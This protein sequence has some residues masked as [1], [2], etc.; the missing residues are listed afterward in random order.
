MRIN[1]IQIH[2]SKG[3]LPVPLRALPHRTVLPSQRALPPNLSYIV[4]QF[5]YRPLIVLSSV[6]AGTAGSLTPYLL[7]LEALYNLSHQIF[8]QIHP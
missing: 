6:V 8:V 5:N 4:L 3:I 1:L 7:L 2:G